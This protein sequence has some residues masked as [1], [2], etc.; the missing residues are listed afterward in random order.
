MN[1]YNVQYKVFYEGQEINDTFK[2]VVEAENEQD[3]IEKARQVLAPFYNELE[4]T[5]ATLA[6]SYVVYAYIESNA[7]D[8]HAYHVKASSHDDAIVQAKLAYDS[9]SNAGYFEPFAV[10]T[11]A[12]MYAFVRVWKPIN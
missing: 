9:E 3:A 1:K 10:S 12:R 2:V 11:V 4:I 5:E 7:M 8:I 6:D